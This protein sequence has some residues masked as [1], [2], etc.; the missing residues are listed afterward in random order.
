MGRL[1][2]ST[3]ILFVPSLLPAPKLFV[4]VVV[5]LLGVVV[6]V[7][8]LVVR[9]AGVNARLQVQQQPLRNHHA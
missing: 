3:T 8:A 6:V 7:L 9:V 5:V 4:V 2:D 1:H